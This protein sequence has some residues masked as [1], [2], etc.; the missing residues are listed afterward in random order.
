MERCKV[1]DRSARARRRELS[2]YAIAVL[3]GRGELDLGAAGRPMC[4]D[5]FDEI[6]E[7]LI[8]MEHDDLGR[9]SAVSVNAALIARAADEA[10]S[11]VDLGDVA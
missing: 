4:D 9:S 2:G 5:C 8:D 3:I 7:T 11:A 6:R 10:P 1:C